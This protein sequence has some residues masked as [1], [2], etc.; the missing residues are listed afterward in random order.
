MFAQ[1]TSPVERQLQIQVVTLLKCAYEEKNEERQEKGGKEAHDKEGKA[2]QL[3]TPRDILAQVC[4]RKR[5]D[6]LTPEY[7]FESTR[8]FSYRVAVVFQCVV[9]C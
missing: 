7:F 8:G 4:A 6:A 5:A 2:P 1:R 9:S 3:A